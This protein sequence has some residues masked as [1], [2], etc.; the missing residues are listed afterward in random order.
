LGTVLPLLGVSHHLGHQGNL[1]VADELS[2][3]IQSLEAFERAI[4][5]ARPG[6]T[7]V[8]ADG[9]YDGWKLNVPPKVSGASGRMISIRAETPGGVV[10]T[11][12]AHIFIRGNYIEL[13]DLVF[14]ET[15]TLSI[16]IHG[17][18]NRVT[19]VDFKRAG[20]RTNTHWP[21]LR[22]ESPASDNEIDHC[23][24]LGSAS[25]SIQVKVDSDERL[26]LRNNIHHNLFKD[27][28]R[29]SK[30]GQE[31]I[32]LLCRLGRVCELMT[33]VEYNSFVR[34]DGDDE[35]VSV[36]SSRN[37]IRYNT[38]SDSNGGITLRAGDDNLVEGNVLI[39]TKR[40][41]VVTGDRQVV[42]NNFIDQPQ[43]EG[44][45]IAVGSKRFRAATN[46]ILAHNTIT[47]A[48]MPITFALRDGVEMKTPQNN[49]IVNNILVG[50]EENRRIISVEGANKLDEYL[51]M[52]EIKQNIFWYQDGVAS[53]RQIAEANGNIV[54][55]PKLDFSDAKI[56]RSTSD[57]PARHRAMPGFATMDLT[58][59]PRSTK[60][61]PDI[62]AVESSTP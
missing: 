40:G 35:L 11:G 29:Y 2:Q 53:T 51:T 34:A 24:F 37:M 4:A 60:S 46:S 32:Q 57:S 26:P 10:L 54:A 15:G 22:I 44:I 8:I 3:P 13:A 18:H 27:I 17:D 1:A 33:R 50:Q 38:A 58:G 48:P 43:R 45:L 31:P 5:A 23:E 55:D 41:V 61:L 21:I 6:D 7:I 62:G 47:R 9:R 39:R 28:R 19:Q 42:I 25:V 20:T 16:A 49:R 30:N 14:E 36:K 59:T 52:N 12:D 56:P